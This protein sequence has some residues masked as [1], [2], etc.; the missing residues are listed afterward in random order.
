MFDFYIYGNK[1]NHMTIVLALWAVMILAG[2]V[3]MTA[4]D[5]ICSTE[6]DNRTSCCSQCGAMDLAKNMVVC[7]YGDICVPCS[8]ILYK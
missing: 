2:W 3:I 5:K 8:R 6:E 7:K 1:G 4:I